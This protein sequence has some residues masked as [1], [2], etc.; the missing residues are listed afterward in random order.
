MMIVE[1]RRNVDMERDLPDGVAGAQTNPL[2][3]GAVLLLSFGKLLLGAESLVALY[4][5][6][7]SHVS[8]S[9]YFEWLRRRDSGKRVD[10]RGDSV[11]GKDGSVY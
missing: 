3:D 9:V 10:T 4:D 6:K 2:R 5:S 7:N 8:Y 11:F 1:R